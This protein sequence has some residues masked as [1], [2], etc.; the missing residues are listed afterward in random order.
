LPATPV[1][2]EGRDQF[3]ARELDIELQPKPS[4]A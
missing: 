4:R 3:E 2:I 1:L